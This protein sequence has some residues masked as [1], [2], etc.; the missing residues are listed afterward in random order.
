MV[1]YEDGE[2][3]LFTL[4]FPQMGHHDRYGKFDDDHRLAA[5]K[6]ITEIRPDLSIVGYEFIKWTDIY[7]GSREDKVGWMFGD[8][9]YWDGIREIYNKPKCCI[10]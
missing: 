6:Y 1:K 5:I 7:E 2:G 10:A 4:S 9:E 8:E 3:N